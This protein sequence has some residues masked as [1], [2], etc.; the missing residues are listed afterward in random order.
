VYVR[1]CI[2]REGSYYAFLWPNPRLLDFRDGAWVK[3]TRGGQTRY[4]SIWL[5]E[6]SRPYLL[7]NQ[8]VMIGNIE[9][10]EADS[11]QLLEMQKQAFS[12]VQRRSNVQAKRIGEIL[13]GEYQEIGQREHIPSINFYD[14][15]LE[16][17]ESQAIAVRKALAVSQE[18]M[19]FLIHGPPGTGKTTVITEIVRHL[20]E[21]D[22]RVL[23]TSHT[24]VAVNNVME[25]LLHACTCEPT[26]IATRIGSLMGSCSEGDHYSSFF[27]VS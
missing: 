3:I 16:K 19:F 2:E 22:K 8:H 9:I 15:R 17:I 4:G 24:N 10:V 21:M 11:I 6:E 27:N 5:T 13:S 14:K 20:A 12:R 26:S 25:N 18:E 23:I 7:T 1:Q